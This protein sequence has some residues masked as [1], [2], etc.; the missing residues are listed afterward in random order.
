M[1]AMWTRFL[2]HMDF[3]RT[4]VRSGRLGRVTSVHADHAQRLPSDP[5]HRI[6]DPHRAGGALLDLGIYPISFVCE[7]L[8]EPH[9]VA[10][11][12][13]FTD[14]GVDGSVA[15]IC[16]HRDDA[17]STTFSSS[18][19]RGPN[20][21]VVLGTEARLEISAFWYAPAT[22]SVY[23]DDVVVDTFDQPVSGRGMQYQAAELEH[24]LSSG[25]ITSPLLTPDQSVSIMAVMDEIRT[26]IG[27]RY[28]GEAD[29]AGGPP[30]HR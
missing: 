12:A 21:A 28:P 4:T 8:G 2:P 14:T 20:T 11:T 13:T 3:V 29:A 18:R 5:R 9:E 15:T 7:L 25:Q 19:T 6:N 16:R 22:V 17:L 10:A 24:R 1:E 26:A 27:L 30:G 23:E